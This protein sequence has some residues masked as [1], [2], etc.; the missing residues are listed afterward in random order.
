MS[1]HEMKGFRAI[2]RSTPPSVQDGKGS[3]DVALCE[4]LEVAGW[5]SKSTKR[6][7][8]KIDRTLIPFLSLLY[9]LSFLDRTNIGNAR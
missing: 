8:S 7:L 5:D 1:D 9:L 4:N 3:V 2:D 6:L